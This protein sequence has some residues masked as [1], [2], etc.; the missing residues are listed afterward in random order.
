MTQPSNAA[1]RAEL[2][3]EA[4][5][6]IETSCATIFLKGDE[7][8]KLKKPV[9]FG[10][11]DYS[12][13]DK[14]QWALERELL[15]NQETAPHIYQRI[16]HVADEPVLVMRRF[17][18]GAVLSADPAQVGPD[19]AERLGRE[20]ACFH[21]RARITPD[22]GGRANMD[23]VAGSN[24]GHIRHFAAALGAAA[25]EDLVARTE[26]LIEAM[27]PLMQARQAAGFA[28]RC[29]GDLHLGNV[30]LE[31]GRPV[32]FDC[33][34][35]N[36]TLSQIDCLY[37][38]AFVL[39][40]LSFRGH[41]PAANRVMSAY[42]DEAARSFDAALWDGLAL[43]PLYMAVRAGVRCHVSAHA[44]DLALAGQYLDFG[45]ALLEGGTPT[46]IAI[47]GLSGSGK[48]TEARR[49]APALS[50]LPGAVVL[51]TD[52]LRKRLWGVDPLVPLPPAAYTPDFGARVYASLIET[53][54]QVLKAGHSVV[55]DAVFLRP[56][57]RAAAEAL[58][59][60]QGV[61]FTGLWM[62]APPEDLAAR[63]AA[64]TNDA[65]DATPAVLGQQL[66]RDP[67]PLN[68]T[69]TRL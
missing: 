45:R 10:F 43:L 44:G 36:D 2:G 46:L 16:E 23:Y 26:A 29:H 9:D 3:R 50:P 22:G 30:F 66:Q 35:F 15:F 13:R 68:W 60:A 42:L 52:E 21:A 57:E 48:S 63:I 18:D 28:R 5:R 33:I 53:A 31:D 61:P 56:E 65:S 37:D 7:A 12:T 58:A 24:A 38:L 1:A 55:L 27:A 11:L 40:D 49:R 41:A 25:V 32:L 59:Q 69:R 62:E 54:A 20:I 8:R 4:E 34:E 51:R 67:G 14:R 6:V 47:G 17:D 39:M 19:L 64:R